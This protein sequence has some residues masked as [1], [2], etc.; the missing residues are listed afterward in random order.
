[1][2]NQL[3]KSELDNNKTYH[4]FVNIVV[5]LNNGTN[6]YY[7]SFPSKKSEMMDVIHRFH[8]I[9]E[10]KKIETLKTFYVL[11]DKW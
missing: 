6:V 11:K 5:F 3:S 8:L 7:E 9:D 10:I 2:K 4:K 1:M